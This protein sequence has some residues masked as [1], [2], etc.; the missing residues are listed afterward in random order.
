M[1][2]VPHKNGP[3]SFWFAPLQD[4]N[5]KIYPSLYA[6]PSSINMTNIRQHTELPPTARSPGQN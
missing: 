6:L 1:G 4:D 3:I 5:F 2:Q